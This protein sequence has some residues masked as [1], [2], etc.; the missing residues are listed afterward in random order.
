MLSNTYDA[1]S[2]YCTIAR[3]QKFFQDLTKIHAIASLGFYNEG[4]SKSAHYLLL[5]FFLY[6]FYIAPSI[7]GIFLN[8]LLNAHAQHYCSIVSKNHF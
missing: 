7:F 4:R 5:A 2:I 3:T 1:F 8:I 6:L